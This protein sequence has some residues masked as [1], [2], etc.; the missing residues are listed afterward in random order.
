MALKSLLF[1][2]AFVLLVSTTMVTSTEEDAIDTELNAIECARNT[3]KRWNMKKW[4]ARRIANTAAENTNASQDIT[5]SAPP[6][7]KFKLALVEYNY[8]AIYGENAKK[9][10]DR[11]RSAIVDL[12]VEYGGEL[13][14]SFV[15][16]STVALESTFIVGGRVIDESRAA[17]LPD[18]VEALVTTSDW[19]EKKEE[20]AHRNGCFSPVW[21]LRSHQIKDLTCSASESLLFYGYMFRHKSLPTRSTKVLMPMHM[22]RM[23]LVPQ[24]NPLSEVPHIRPLMN[25]RTLHYIPFLGHRLECTSSLAPRVHSVHLSISYT[26]KQSHLQ[27]S[28]NLFLHTGYVRILQGHGILPCQPSTKGC[29]RTQGTTGI[30]LRSNRT[31]EHVNAQ[32][33]I[34]VLKT[35]MQV[36]SAFVWPR[37][38]LLLPR[39]SRATIN[40]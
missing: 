6:G 38:C 9:Y 11:V 19:L 32:G 18:V 7:T 26:T 40:P 39:P 21:R 27:P 12:F 4:N 17:L 10:V 30:L 35:P 25:T 8:N 29:F 20:E 13:Y 2:F 15:P 14:P 24:C 34:P 31:K 3:A 33:P 28:T 16:A 36:L 5:T 37:P 23:T 22:L 1:V